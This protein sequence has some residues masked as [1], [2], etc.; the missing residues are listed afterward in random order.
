[1]MQKVISVKY[2]LYHW[3]DQ[4]YFSKKIR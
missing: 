1:M 4:D 3:L 2:S